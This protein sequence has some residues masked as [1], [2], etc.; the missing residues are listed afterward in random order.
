MP[1]HRLDSV[2]MISARHGRVQGPFATHGCYPPWLPSPCRRLWRAVVP[3]ELWQFYIQPTEIEA[4]FKHLKDDLRL[5]PIYHQLERT[6]SSP[7][8]PIA[9]T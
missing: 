4:P 7:S 1:L 9:C 5:R 8:W 6:S 2:S 3:A